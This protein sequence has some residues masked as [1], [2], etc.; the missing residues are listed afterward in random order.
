[1]EGF[2]KMNV[3]GNIILDN[4]SSYKTISLEGMWKDNVGQIGIFE[5]NGKVDKL[6]EIP[7]IEAVGYGKSETNE[8]FW[9]I[10]KRNKRDITVGGGG[11][12]EYIDGTGRYK[13][14]IGLKCPYVA[15]Y[16]EGR[17][18]HISKCNIKKGLLQELKNF[19]K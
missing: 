16:M 8:K 9:F 19:K 3:T 17:N 4:N 10:A 13:K 18:F 15:R 1:M 2:F 6:D 11:T 14:L 5:A 12:L 7:D